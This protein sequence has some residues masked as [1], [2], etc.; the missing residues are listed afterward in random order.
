MGQVDINAA[1]YFIF[2]PNNAEELMTVGWGSE[3]TQF[4]GLGR[5]NQHDSNKTPTVNVK[6][7][8]NLYL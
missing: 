5:K 6:L 8:Y 4:Q 2:E 1:H 3:E 7:L